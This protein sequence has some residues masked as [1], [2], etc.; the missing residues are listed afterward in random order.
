VHGIIRYNF[1]WISRYDKILTSLLRNNMPLKEIN[2]VLKVMKIDDSEE[3]DGWNDEVIKIL[4]DN[5]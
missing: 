5:S 1:S 2:Q 4:K 3:L